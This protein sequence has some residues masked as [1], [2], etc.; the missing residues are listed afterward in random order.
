MKIHDEGEAIGMVLAIEHLSKTITIS[1]SGSL[2]PV[3]MRE[4]VIV[5]WNA[6]E[7]EDTESEE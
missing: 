2:P 4:P 3:V 7:R 6:L 5:G 1:F